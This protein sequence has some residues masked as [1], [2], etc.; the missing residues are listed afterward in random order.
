MVSSVGSSGVAVVVVVVVV[1]VVLVASRR[2][3]RKTAFH[4]KLAEGGGGR[5]APA[6]VVEGPE[7]VPITAASMT[8][9]QW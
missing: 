1:A 2:V 7:E 4:C 3:T 8:K 6:V 9:K 5:Q